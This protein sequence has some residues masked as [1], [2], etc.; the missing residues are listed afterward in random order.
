MSDILSQLA[1]K[2]GDQ[3]QTGHAPV[4]QW[5]P[6]YCGELD[7]EIKAN[8]DWYYMGSPI[9]RQ[10]LVK[11]FASVLWR[12]SEADGAT[13][14]VT[15]V[16]KIKIKVEDAAFLATDMLVQGSGTSQNIAIQTNLAGQLMLGAEHGIRFDT[17]N[18]QF[19]AYI[20]VRFGLEAKLTRSLTIELV[21]YLIKKGEQYLLISGGVEFKVE[22]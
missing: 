17:R 15:P 21:E 1:Q 11:L 14:L 18:D 3:A 22:P 20:M 13:Y 2:L 16:E 7:I 12:D 19:M 4:D 8:G 9:K 10:K 5:S 6:Q